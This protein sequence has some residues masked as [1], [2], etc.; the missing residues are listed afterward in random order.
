MAKY[1]GKRASRKLNYDAFHRNLFE[2]EEWSQLLQRHG[3]S[4]VSLKP[5]QPE[6]FTFWYRMSRLVGSRFG[7]TLLF[8]RIK[9][10]LWARYK[11]EIVAMVKESINNTHTGG[12]IFVIAKKC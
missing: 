8:P 2:V 1:I 12:N 4:V 11:T 9:E 5:F 10:T 7:L 6:R 3:F